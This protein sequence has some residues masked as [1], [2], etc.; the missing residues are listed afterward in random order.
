MCCWYGVSKIFV[1]C[2]IYT[3]NNYLNKKV[4]RID[5]LPNLIC[6]EKGF[7]FIGNRNINIDN[8]WKDGLHLTEQGKSKLS[9]N[10]IHF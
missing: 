5:F 6:K 9:R 2:L 1:L 4:T 7:V 3:K 10:L 8:L